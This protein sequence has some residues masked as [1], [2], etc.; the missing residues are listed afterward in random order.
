MARVAITH[1]LLSRNVAMVTSFPLFFIYCN[2][3]EQQNK[4][5]INIKLVFIYSI[6]CT[7]I[8]RQKMS[9]NQYA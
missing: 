1:S 8:K 4:N 9:Q 5:K 2:D 7:Y 6:L 3:V